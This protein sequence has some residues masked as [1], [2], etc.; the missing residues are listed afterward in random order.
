MDGYYKIQVDQDSVPIEKYEKL[1]KEN[2]ELKTILKTIY[3]CTKDI[4]RVWKQMKNLIKFILITLASWLLVDK[5][6]EI[7]TMN[8]I[9]TVA[10]MILGVNVF[11]FIK[12]L[13]RKEG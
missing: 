12:D 9:M 10:Y 13:R 11:G 6:S 2:I 5:L 3:N 4:E 1:K 7:I 8:Q